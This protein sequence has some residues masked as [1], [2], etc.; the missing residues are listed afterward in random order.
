MKYV[1]IIRE[2]KEVFCSVLPLKW[3]PSDVHEFVAWYTD[4]MSCAQRS[5]MNVPSEQFVVVSL[6]SLGSSPKKIIAE[7]F[8]LLDIE[9]TE[10]IIDACTS[11]ID[12]LRSITHRW[13]SRLSLEEKRMIEN[14]CYALYNFWKQRD[15]GSYL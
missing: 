12:P 1:H 9:F 3:G 5:Y 2:P 11:R 4:V 6:E 7:I 8:G 14:E 10:V 13:V 15:I